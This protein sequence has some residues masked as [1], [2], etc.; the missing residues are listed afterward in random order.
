M[1]EFFKAALR[2]LRV[3]AADKQ[4]SDLFLKA[5][6]NASYLSWRVQNH[7]ISL[8]GGAIQKQ[9][10]SDISQCKYFSIIADETTDLSQSNLVYPFGLSKIPKCTKN[11]CVLFQL[12]QQQARSCI[13][14]SHPTISTWA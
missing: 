14:D 6:R 8:M 10:I 2:L 7:I 1:T 3:E 12:L 9:I 11:F 4:T 5:P 13:Y